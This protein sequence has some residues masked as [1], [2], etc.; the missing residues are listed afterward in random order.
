MREIECR[1]R[2][3][4]DIRIDMARQVSEPGLE[5][6]ERTS[7]GRAFNEYTAYLRAV[8]INAFIVLAL[9]HDMRPPLEEGDRRAIRTHGVWNVH[10]A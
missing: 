1:D 6:I 2:R 8:S 10:L 9:P 5:R 7:V 4:T 3:L